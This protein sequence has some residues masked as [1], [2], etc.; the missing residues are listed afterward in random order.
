M[1]KTTA[2]IFMNGRSQ[3]VRLPKQFRVN[4]KEVYISR[5]NDSI[6][7]TPKPEKFNSREELEAFFT[8]ISC[9]DFDLD[10]DMSPPQ[11]RDFFH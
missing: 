9:P 11:D 8:S 6:I 1:A 10:R 7:I 2:K 4:T 3:A 5:E